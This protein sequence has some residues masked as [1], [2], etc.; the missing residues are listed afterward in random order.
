MS[1]GRANVSMRDTVALA[2][3]ADAIAE[4]IAAQRITTVVID[5]EVDFSRL[6]LAGPIAEATHAHCIKLE[7]LRLVRSISTCKHA[8][9]GRE[10]IRAPN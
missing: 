9:R 10:P 3:E 6:G 8:R 2:E 5:T 7:E 1:D 4:A